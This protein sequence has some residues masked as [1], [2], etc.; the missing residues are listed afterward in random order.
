M[1]AGNSKSVNQFLTG[2]M[3]NFLSEYSKFNK[4]VMRSNLNKPLN[5]TLKRT[6]TSANQMV[7]N[8][9]RH[10]VALKLVNQAANKLPNAAPAPPPPPSAPVSQAAGNMAKVL[11]EINAALATVPNNRNLTVNNLGKYTRKNSLNSNI[12]TASRANNNKKLARSA[13]L[14]KLKGIRVGNTAVTTTEENLAHAGA[15]AVAAKAAYDAILQEA[16]A[17]NRQNLANIKALGNGMN[18]SRARIMNAKN[19]Q[20]YTNFRTNVNIKT[21]ESAIGK[22]NQAKAQ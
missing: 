3:K 11:A 7:L 16:T 13:K 5:G 2:P 19:S 1:G 21:F 20:K 9:I 18:A 8:G 12:N 6:L 22:I 4:N 14:A 17:I 10:Y 15:Q